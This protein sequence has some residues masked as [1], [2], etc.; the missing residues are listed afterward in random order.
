MLLKVFFS[1]NSASER[2]HT[3]N[4]MFP[5]LTDV[6]HGK[7][8]KFNMPTIVECVI[9]PYALNIITINLASFRAKIS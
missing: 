4:L 9:L 6:N 3:T 1:K 2:V 8:V 7:Y 5:K